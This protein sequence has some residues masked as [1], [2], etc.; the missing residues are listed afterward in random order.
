MTEYVI[1][2]Y[3]PVKLFRFFEDISRIPRGS[4]NEKGIADFLVAFAEER[5]IECYR[6][7]I[8]NVYYKIPATKGREAEPSVLL[9][10]HTDMV[11]EKNNDTVH[12]FLTDPLSLYVDERGQLRARGTTLGG[13]DGVAVVVMMAAAD[14]MIPSHPTLECLFTVSEEVGLEG[15]NGFDYSRISSRILLNMDSEEEDC[16]IVGCAGGVRSDLL[17][18]IGRETD[19][20]GF[21]RAIE[22]RVKGLKGGHSGEDINKGRANA[23]KLVGRLLSVA[24]G[25]AELRL[26]SIVGGSKDNAIPR[27]CTAV[28]ALSAADADKVA[29]ALRAEGAK[30]AESLCA[31][32][33]GFVLELI[34]KP[35]VNGLFDKKMTDGLVKLLFEV[36][37]GVL[38]MID[39]TNAVEWSRSLGVIETK[40][41]IVRVV[42]SSR[43][44]IESELDASVDELNARAEAI[45]AT[46]HHHGRYPGWEYN[47]NSAIRE[48]Y[49]ALCEKMGMPTNVRV[50]HAGLECG[51]IASNLPGLDAISFGPNMAD[52]HSPEEALDLASTA[53][54]WQKLVMLLAEPF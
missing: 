50:I 7:A 36:P 9:Q 51:V 4:G 39:G 37:N 52:I 13:D 26:A 20:A 19:G 1:S 31:D 34:E 46:V 10:G 23:N 30:I 35:E 40:E 29:A 24:S 54:F 32:D 8:H 45:G 42:F 15:A 6:D 3:E 38:K 47:P 18:P 17:L 11:C 44:A 48:R 43:S 53:R 28:V 12:N 21:D 27:E 5:G 2:G 41:D 33:R 25:V 14:G 16:V 22:I 49:L